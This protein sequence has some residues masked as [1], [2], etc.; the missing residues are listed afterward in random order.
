MERG[1]KM[2]KKKMFSA[3]AIFLI[4]CS[5]F[6]IIEMSSKRTNEF[7][8]KKNSFQDQL[9][10]S[11]KYDLLDESFDE[12]KRSILQFT[13][14]Y[15][16]SDRSS[17]LEERSYI[18]S[19][20][21]NFYRTDLP[22]LYLIANEIAFTFSGTIQQMHQGYL[23]TNGEWAIL[24]EH[25]FSLLL[26]ENSGKIIDDLSKKYS[27]VMLASCNSELKSKYYSNVFGFN[28]DISVKEIFDDLIYQLPYNSMSSILETNLK[29]YKLGPFDID[30]PC[31]IPVGSKVKSALKTLTGINLFFGYFV[32]F[33]NAVTLQWGTD[34]DYGIE[35]LARKSET[36]YL[37]YW[38][39]YD[40]FLDHDVKWFIFKV[41]DENYF[42]IVVFKLDMPRFLFNPVGLN[43]G[44][45]IAFAL[46]GYPGVTLF[47]PQGTYLYYTIRTAG[48]WTGVKPSDRLMS[49][50]YQANAIKWME[51]HECSEDDIFKRSGY[52]YTFALLRAALAIF[53]SLDEYLDIASTIKWWQIV[54]A[55]VTTA[56]IITVG[57]AFA[58]PSGGTSLAATIAAAAIV[59]C[60]IV[61][62]F[63]AISPSTVPFIPPNEPIGP[64]STTDIGSIMPLDADEVLDSNDITTI[65]GLID[66]ELMNSYDD[67][68]DGITNS[69]EA[70]YYD[71][72]IAKVLDDPTNPYEFV[73][74][75][76]P[77][78]QESI[79][80]EYKYTWLDPNE[81]YD[82]DGLLTITEVNLK[83]D[84][85][86][87]DTDGDGLMDNEEIILSGNSETII[88][89]LT[90]FDRDGVLDNQ[91]ITIQEISEFRSN[92]SLYD[93]DHDGLGDYDEIMV[94]DTDPY[95]RD[96]DDD[97][98]L[99][100]WEVY[101]YKIKWQDAPTGTYENYYIDYVNPKVAPTNPSWIGLDDDE[102]GLN[103]TMESIFFTNPYV[104]DSDNDGLDDETELEYNL[105]PTNSHDVG[106]DHDYD[107]LSTLSEISIYETNI[108]SN[109]S[110]NDGLLDYEEINTYGTNP[111]S[112]DTD[113]DGI[114]DYE[115]T[116]SGSDGFI[117]NP[118]DED[119]DGDGI[120]D[121]EEI[122][123]G[124]D[125]YITNPVDSDTDDDGL[126]DGMEI[127]YYLT[128]PCDSD[129]DN[130]DLSDMDEVI[131]QF[132]DP[133][134]AD[135]D[136]DGLTDGDE[137]NL[138]NTDPT[139]ADSD[140]DFL[141]DGLEVNTYQTE[142]NDI[143]TDDDGLLDGHEVNAYGTNPN[144][145]DSDY[146]GLTDYQEVSTYGS[147]PLDTDSDN[148][149]LTDGYEVNTLGTDPTT[150]D[151]DEDGLLDGEEIILGD[152]GFIT[153][154]LDSDCDDDQLLDG[155]EY[156]HNTNPLNHDT[157]GDSFC[158]YHE[159]YTYSTDP[160]N[161]N[162]N[163]ATYSPNICRNFHGLPDG[164]R[165]V[166]FTW[167]APTNYW[168]GD[169]QWSAWIYVLKI[170]IGTTWYT[171]YSGTSRSKNYQPPSAT[172]SYSYRLY[173]YNPH[174]GV[175][176][177]YLSWY[178]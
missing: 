102:D 63:G 6:F 110:D 164:I 136:E 22:I 166:Y 120:N 162:S 41:E 134:N 46:L 149:G 83:S 137:I 72:Y 168:A 30:D 87:A 112:N 2:E 117:T 141:D 69:V 145:P 17:S 128:D 49:R 38:V 28:G 172:T 65:A 135:T 159:I 94:Y 154:P 78:E 158:D 92:P 48:I 160:L 7:L 33:H 115:E 123:S 146:D 5:S 106:F 96:T 138:Y 26:S 39:L 174:T 108:V 114:Y 70:S 140:N 14:E 109:D 3:M 177:T 133:N 97:T 157:D 9:K 142:P 175:Y 60:A 76:I 52:Q 10:Y 111:I 80:E 42:K 19:F 16:L 34:E 24:L 88:A 153:D 71:L 176:S 53:N 163:P 171:I 132:T 31:L 131:Y 51:N 79:P 129:T 152:D 20:I 21:S 62:V 126:G 85:I 99:D 18:A 11:Y 113:N 47:E 156:T 127:I 12:E 155:E 130:D 165:K 43:Q 148:D 91:T 81:D 56:A 118:T 36:A 125:G 29:D 27:W 50:S 116:V 86:K 84:P 103:N 170:K 74:S 45:R 147:D 64:L 90:D 8:I 122:T 95:D 58:V 37:N 55:A 66:N 169:P 82:N 4:V 89:P 178:G 100:G 167:N 23:I 15:L 54:L 121:Y 73:S 143:D 25:G 59:A 119:T 104:A 144:N 32:I 77:E 173:C 98:L 75:T 139:D 35:H 44:A 161:Y 93:S 40:L 124:T 13:N 101:T 105:D 1:R 150:E 68:N 61:G 151:T 67:D 107:G 57:V